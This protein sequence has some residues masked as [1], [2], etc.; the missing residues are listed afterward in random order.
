MKKTVA[1][2]LALLLPMIYIAGA[3][4][5]EAQVTAATPATAQSAIPAADSALAYLTKN[6]IGTDSVKSSI[7]SVII[8][9]KTLNSVFTGFYGALNENGETLSSIGVEISVDGIAASLSRYP[10]VSAAVRSYPT[11]DAL[12]AA[13]FAPAWNVASREGFADAL[14][15][16]FSPF[17]PLLYCLLCSGDYRVSG[18]VSL[19]GADGYN[20]AVV[21]ALRQIG[22]TYL[23]AQSEFSAAAASD[24]SLMVKYLVASLFS[25]FDALLT[26]PVD[27]LCSNLPSVAGFL[28]NDGISNLITSLTDP[29]TVRIGLLPLPG[30]T[31]LISKTS[32]FSDPAGLS[33]MLNKAD[34]SSVAGADISLPDIDLDALSKCATKG[35]AF[36]FILTYAVNALKANKNAIPGAAGMGS[37]LSANTDTIVNKLIELLNTKVFGSSL[38]YQWSFPSHTPST[39][40][41]PEGLS[42][43]QATS[44]LGKVDSVLNEFASEFGGGSLSDSLSAA[45]YSPDIF[46]TVAS[47]LKKQL[48]DNAGTL[49]SALGINLSAAEN[50]GFARGS[51]SGFERTLHSVFSSAAPA[52]AYLLCG[53]DFRLFDTFVL[54]GS[55][56]YSTCLAPIYEALGCRDIRPVAEISALQGDAL[57]TAVF[58]PLLDLLDRLTETPIATVCEILPNL[59][60][61]V[62]NGMLEQC[63]R[64]L[65][66]PVLKA[67]EASGLGDIIDI[68]DLDQLDMS[69]IDIAS[70]IG[71]AGGDMP[72]KV[73]LS[74]LD[75]DAIMSLG[76]AVGYKSVAQFKGANIDAVRIDADKTAVFI[77]LFRFAVDS[78]KSQDGGGLAGLLPKGDNADGSDMMSVYTDKA[79]AELE[80]MTTDE[81]IVWLY[82]LLFEETPTVAPTEE[83]ETLPT[84]IYPRKSKS[85]TGIYAAGVG[86]IAAAAVTVSIMRRRR[87]D[88]HS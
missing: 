31:R 23:P 34:L 4:S 21:P 42:Y 18:L 26:P 3:F 1:L 17:E 65:L 14:S 46:R 64:N 19:Q 37:L 33:G 22:C 13:D 55:N 48:G 76:S 69:N 87:R 59:I 27:G 2:I 57:V 47:G 7:E 73:D 45:I 86:V 12:V 25:A 43:E 67:V 61:F 53:K 50:A 16:I 29:L 80:A 85:P 71:S 20:D 10:E 72:L 40:E 81:V 5:A 8:S 58:A 60:W 38:E 41:M 44:M 11:V 68:P 28:V 78:M 82:G 63:V 32:A 52:L 83:N 15:C 54:R 66:H 30:L 24:K 79:I 70:L 62:K 6:Y 84:V 77:T 36:I 35:D 9:D 88:A 39:V 75:T 51:R 56:G 74:A 49:L